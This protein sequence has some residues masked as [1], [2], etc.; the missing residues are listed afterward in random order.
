VFLG[1]GVFSWDG[2]WN[3]F[4]N[5]ILFI[6]LLQIQRNS[7]KNRHLSKKLEM[8]LPHFYTRFKQVAKN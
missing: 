1:G 8:G 4:A 2:V 5:V 6:F 3:F 7:E